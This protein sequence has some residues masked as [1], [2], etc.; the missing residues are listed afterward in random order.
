MFQKGMFMMLL[1]PLS[2]AG[3]TLTALRYGAIR[4]G[5]SFIFVV[6][7]EALFMRL[8]LKSTWRRS[9]WYSFTMNLASSVLG[10]GL[11]LASPFAPIPLLIIFAYLLTVAVEFYVLKLMF[12]PSSTNSVLVR[13]VAFVNLVSYFCIFV[14]PWAFGSL[15][16]L[17]SVGQG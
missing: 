3:I 8:Y 14:L 5:I 4:A 7:L 10:L 1:S 17:R 13:F 2:D 11:V 15:N 12:R 6:L 9:L 16:L